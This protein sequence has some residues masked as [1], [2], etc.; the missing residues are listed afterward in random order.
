VVVKLDRLYDVGERICETN[1]FAAVFVPM[2]S[3]R[4]EGLKPASDKM[5]ALRADLEARATPRLGSGALLDLL[6]WPACDRC[7]GRR[8]TLCRDCGG[9]VGRVPCDC[10]SM[11]PITVS[12][13][14]FDIRLV[15]AV[16]DR[17]GLTSESTFSYGV[18]RSSDKWELVLLSNDLRGIVMGA[19]FDKDETGPVWP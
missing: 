10:D 6:A 12:G 14:R 1:G 17:M 2:P 19:R 5:R 7:Q 4:P 15:R 8:T 11:R 13:D 9:E 3:D 18:S 16:A